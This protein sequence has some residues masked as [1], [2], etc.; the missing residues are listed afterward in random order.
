M[1]E[2][3]KVKELILIRVESLK[4][5]L[6]VIIGI[7]KIVLNINPMFVMHVMILALLDKIYVTFLLWLLKM[8]T[9]GSI[10]VV[11]IKKAAVFI[12]KNSDLRDRS[13]L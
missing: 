12:L 3:T 1:K 7:L 13:V 9:I 8:L 5:A 10:V 11:L 2:L 6:F 4:N